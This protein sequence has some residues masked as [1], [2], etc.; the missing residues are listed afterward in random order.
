MQVDDM[1]L[2]QYDSFKTSYAGN[3]GTNM[4]SGM[5]AFYAENKGRWH[6]VKS[7]E[8]VKAKEGKP[9]FGASGNKLTYK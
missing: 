9:K 6:A 8:I 5:M 4:M 2:W 3:M 1:I 7:T